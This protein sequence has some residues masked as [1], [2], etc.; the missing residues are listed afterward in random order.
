MRNKYVNHAR[1]VWERACKHL[2]RVDQFWVKYAYM[3]EVLGN[4]DRVRAIFEDWMTWIPTEN[5]W[6]AFLKFEER[7]GDNERCRS[8]LEKYIDAFPAV[9]SYIKAAKF[10]ESHRERDHARLYYERALA[11]LGH[12]AFDEN[13]FIQ[14]TKYEL[15]QKEFERAKILFKYA[16]DNL[17]KEKSQKLYNQFL[18]FE[19]QHGTREEMEEAVLTKRRHYLEQEVT[20]EPFNYDNWF[21]YVRLEEQNGSIERAREIYE[22]AIVNVPPVND[23][24]FW[25]RYIYLWLNYA[26]FE[27]SQASNSERA[28]QIYEK[29]LFE[30]IPHDTFTFAK[31]WILYAQFLVRQKQID[32]A[33]KVMGQAIGRCPRRKVFK[34]YAQMEEKLAQFDRCRK[35]Y[36]RQIEV[37]PE[38]CETWI[39]YGEFEAQLEEYDRAR[40]IYEIAVNRAN[41]DMPENV[42]KSYID[43]EI[44]LQE[45]DKVRELYRRLLSKT[46]HVKVWISF[47]KFEHENANNAVKSRALF[48][49]AYLHFKNNEPELKEERLLVLENWLKLEQSPFGSSE[50]LEAVQAKLPK[51]IKKRR[52]TQVVNEQ[53]GQEVTQ[54]EAG[55]EEYY[56]YLFPDDQQAQKK[57]LKILE[58]A[59]KWK[60]AGSSAAA[61]I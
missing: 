9:N 56:D 26:L 21:D 8:I 29:A 5:A 32:R 39:E 50:L 37:F 18:E 7:M 23:K 57:S 47:G 13:F 58:L 11:E 42:W 4:N 52:K 51:R 22:R 36:E 45:F 25:K 31:L 27:E 24:K 54:E 53:T 17:S 59:H 55:W 44:A 60:K 14:F 10:E 40:S 16:L 2:P 33:R 48:E 41:L 35:I 61:L 28:S 38:S 30:L 12:K 20:K 3:E 15:R 34:A 43:L 49:E 46:K 1:N 19:K 6:N